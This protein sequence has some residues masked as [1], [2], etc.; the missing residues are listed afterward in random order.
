MVFHLISCLELFIR[1]RVAFNNFH[2]SYI[3]SDWAK[4]TVETSL[5]DLS[6]R[7]LSQDTVAV[8]ARKKHS[9]ALSEP[10]VTPVYRSSIYRFNSVEQYEECVGKVPVILTS[11]SFLIDKMSNYFI[12]DLVFNTVFKNVS[13][14]VRGSIG[15]PGGSHDHP[16]V[17]ATPSHGS[18]GEESNMS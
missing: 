6:L 17:A 2:E 9:Q 13:F 11:F 1:V 14:M 3:A 4:P 10:M 12:S 16:K 15:E 7:E 8:S 18:A 5:S